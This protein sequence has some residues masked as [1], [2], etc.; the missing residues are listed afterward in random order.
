MHIDA[1]NWNDRLRDLRVDHD[2]S[3]AFI[4]DMLG[5]SQSYYSKYELGKH[6]IPIEHLVKLCR[7]YGISADFILGLP[8]GL[9][10]PGVTRP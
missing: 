7:F 3:Q 4:A 1:K 2:I 9:D 8:A 10:Y 5:T 6:Q